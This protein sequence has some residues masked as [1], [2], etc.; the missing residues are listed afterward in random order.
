MGGGVGNPVP[1]LLKARW[2]RHET[3]REGLGST[4]SLPIRRVMESCM[5]EEKMA[6][7][8]RFTN[9][10]TVVRMDVVFARRLA[11]AIGR[12]IDGFGKRLA[13]VR[14]S[15]MWSLRGYAMA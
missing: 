5:R 12:A 2:R 3:Q 11:D 9:R 15:V 1:S 14:N 8:M 10:R 4:P 7:R 6:A 13:D